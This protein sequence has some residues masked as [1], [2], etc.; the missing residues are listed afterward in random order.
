[1]TDT[2]EPSLDGYGEAHQNRSLDNILSDIEG[3]TEDVKRR[4]AKLAKLRQR[5]DAPAEQQDPERFDG[6]G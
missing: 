1:M 5:E 3:L 4:R 2:K 6:L